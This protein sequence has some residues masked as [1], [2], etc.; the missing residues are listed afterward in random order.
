MPLLLFVRRYG[1]KLISALT[2]TSDTGTAIPI[3]FAL[4]SDETAI[5]INSLLACIVHRGRGVLPAFIMT[6]GAMAEK[7][8][9]DDLFVGRTVPHMLCIWHVNKAITAHVK[10]AKLPGVGTKMRDTLISELK[11]FVTDALT[12]MDYEHNLEIFL[13][14]YAAPEY[15][16]VVSWFLTNYHPTK[17]KWSVAYRPPQYP[18]TNNTLESK[19]GRNTGIPYI[20]SPDCL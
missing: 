16:E 7:A 20:I 14:K 2:T 6:D 15:L 8:A 18:R 11:F 1:Y 10:R 12:H 3:A 19:E 13:A 17:E 4:A 9:I 5:T